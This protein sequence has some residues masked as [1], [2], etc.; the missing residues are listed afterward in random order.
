M[1]GIAGICSPE[2]DVNIMKD[3]VNSLF[4]RGPDANGIFINETNTVI[5]GNTRLSILDLSE[6]AN[7]PMHTEDGNYTIVYNGEI[8]NFQNLR[9]LI[10]QKSPG[11]VFKTNSDTETVLYAYSILGHD[12][13]PVIEGMFALAIYD[14]K[15]E[16]IFLLR[17][18]L[19]KKP[20]FYYQDSKNFIFASEIKSLLKHPIV[21]NNL[22]ISSRAIYYFLHL[23]Y[24]PEPLTIYDKI[25]KFPAAHYAKFKNNNLQLTPYWQIEKTI[26]FNQ[27]LD[28]ESAILE[29]EMIL[30]IS[31]GNR[32]ISDVPLGIF[33]SGGTDSSLITALS[34][35]ITPH[36]LKTFSIG[37]HDSKYNESGYAKKVASYLGTEHHDF[38]LNEINAIGILENYL[39]HFDEPFAD[40]SAIPTMLVSELARKEVK[41]ALTGDGGDE[42]FLGY[43]AYDWANR[44]GNHSF[45]RFKPVVEAL[46]RNS[47]SSRLKRISNLFQSVRAEELRSHIFSQEQYFFTQKEIHDNLILNNTAD[48]AFKYS[49]PYY[50]LATEA[51]KQALFDINHYLKDDLL[52]KVDRASMFHSLEC[53][54]PFLD[55]KVVEMALRLP[56]KMKK[57][58]GEK[59]WILKQIL[60]KYLPDELIHRPKWGFSI[61]LGKWLKNDLQYLMNDYLNTNVIKNAGIA[62]PIYV[63]NL[64]RLFYKG[65]E[66]LFNRLW[67]L[68]ILHKWLMD[69]R[70]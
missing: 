37:F 34:S 65:D 21:K 9:K 13:L 8:F 40:T 10:K 5:L 45:D 53:R 63:E 41:V 60:K 36:K 55:Y 44:L 66:Y 18:R 69:N 68:I 51:E 12:L 50:P 4:H 23:G 6:K 15:A 57:R 47:S 22:N 19:G 30:T 54:C 32:L 43:G 67:L 26:G 52:V 17:D 48:Y 31:V 7:Q 46:L 38:E 25:K 1:C 64:K 24:I 49:D 39:K 14:K 35:K 28:D 58:N 59:K 27:P 33:L 29:L 3:M 20:L 42:L 2:A 62:D 16:E 61:P 11:T 70:I 56:Y